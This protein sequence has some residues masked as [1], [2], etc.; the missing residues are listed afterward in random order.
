MNKNVFFRICFRLFFNVP[1]AFFGCALE[2]SPHT[3]R[4]E[5]RVEQ[6][7]V[8]TVATVSVFNSLKPVQ[9]ADVTINA[10]QSLQTDGRYATSLP[11]LNP[12]DRVTLSVAV[13]GTDIAVRQ[14]LVMPPTP[15]IDLDLPA[16]PG[17]IPV[18]WPS[19]GSLPDRVVL[20]V[21]AGD[22]ANGEAYTAAYP[23]AN[24]SLDLAAAGLSTFR[25]VVPV[26]I[27]AENAVSLENEALEPD[28]TFTVADSEIL[29]LPLR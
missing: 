27:T 10:D 25:S 4:V 17:E 7:S 28:S 19:A 29:S 14:T 3:V 2:P 23:G 26:T 5:A 20:S 6:N 21:A 22:T 9:N 18:R 24:T 13:P 11:R 1:L 16:A 8:A 15:V 12:G